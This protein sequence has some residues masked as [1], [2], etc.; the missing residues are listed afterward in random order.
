LSLTKKGLQERDRGVF[1]AARSRGIPVM[2]TLAGGYAR[3]VED[4]VG[5]HMNTILAAREIVSELA[6][7]AAG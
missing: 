4:T 1:R 6:R 7:K 2:T 5:I 3:R